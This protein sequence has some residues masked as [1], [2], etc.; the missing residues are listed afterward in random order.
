MAMTEQLI[1]LRSGDVPH[2][3][4]DA[5]VSG[6]A[7]VIFEVASCERCDPLQ[8]SGLRTRVPTADLL[9]P[10]RIASTCVACSTRY[11]RP[12]GA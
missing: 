7:A 5:R 8:K 10:S 6:S 4:I 9:R 12:N 11:V 2:G 3:R 1:P